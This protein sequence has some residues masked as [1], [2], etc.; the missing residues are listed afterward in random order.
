M[1]P[2]RCPRVFGFCSVL[3]ALFVLFLPHT[4]SAHPAAQLPPDPEPP[5]AAASGALLASVAGLSAGGDLTCALLTSGAV[6]CW[7]SGQH[8]QL[9]DGIARLDHQRVL[10]LGVVGLG[11]GVAAISAG[12]YHTCAVTRSGAALCWGNNAYGQLG[13]GDERMRTTPAPVSGLG[14][15]VHALSAGFQHTCALMDTGSVRC[16]GLYHV[17]SPQ[18]GDARQSR[19]PVAVPGLLSGVTAIAA[20]RDHT[21]VLTTQGGVRCWGSNLYGQLGNSSL[22]QT[23][24]RATPVPVD[25]LSRNVT[26]LAAGDHHT[27]AVLGNGTVRCWGSHQYGQLGHRVAAGPK[28]ISMT[29]VEVFQMTGATAVAAGRAHSCAATAAGYAMCWG[30]NEFGQTG[31]GLSTAPRTTAVA[32][33][34]LGSG[35]VRVE[36]G[37]DHACALTADRG[38][39]CWGYNANAQAGH[40]SNTLPDDVMGSSYRTRFPVIMHQP[41]R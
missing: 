28:A 12:R 38:L 29:P 31:D 15:G 33:V 3:L 37:S 35:V 26:A 16:W 10:P 20:G 24:A 30:A 19:T 25:G 40:L 22:A 9:G 14:R 2:S 5:V 11:S 18:G 4:A 32:V 7:G 34:G 27:C 17:G 13:T 39:T 21:C 6:E 41:R 8:G 1:A 23:D 36:A